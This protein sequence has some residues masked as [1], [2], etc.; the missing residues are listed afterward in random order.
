MYN[1]MDICIDSKRDLRLAEPLLLFK[2]KETKEARNKKGPEPS[3]ALAL[4][5]EKGKKR[6][7]E[8]KET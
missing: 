7:K 1:W 6:D 3:G 8:K 4:D 5:P 2:K